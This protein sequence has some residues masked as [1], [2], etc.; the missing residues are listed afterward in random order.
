M[1]LAITGVALLSGVLVA[2]QQFV[3]SSQ[4]R[5]RLVAIDFS[6]FGPD[7]LPHHGPHPRGRD[8]PH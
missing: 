7:G 3:L 2:Q 6:A 4:D 8:P 5:A 1:A